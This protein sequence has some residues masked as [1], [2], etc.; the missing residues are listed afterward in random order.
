MKSVLQR[1]CRIDAEPKGGALEDKK[2]REIGWAKEGYRGGSSS[3]ARSAHSKCEL[4]KKELAL[5]QMT[6]YTRAGL[7]HAL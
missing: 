5:I 2:E 6:V 1:L 7:L 4:Q 3:P